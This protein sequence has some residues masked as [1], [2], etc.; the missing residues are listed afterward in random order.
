MAVAPRAL[1][2]VLLFG[3]V[4]VLV[5]ALVGSQ[6][7]A[8]LPLFA[9]MLPVLI[10]TGMVWYLLAIIIERNTIIE[11]I[12]LWVE[13]LIRQGR[14]SAHRRVNALAAF[15]AF[16]IIAALLGLMAR[17]R[18]AREAVELVV[19]S[20]A[21]VASAG[22]QLAG[23]VLGLGGAPPTPEQAAYTQ[24]IQY[25][26]AL[27]FG[28]IMVVSVTLIVLGVIGGLKKVRDDAL[29]TQEEVGS[30][31]LDT[32][33]ETSRRIEA[34]GDFHELILA[35]YKKMCDLLAVHGAPMRESQTPREFEDAATRVL[36]V[37]R[38]ALE[39]L[40]RLF[41]SARYSVHPVRD[42]DRKEAVDC[43]REIE[44]E[45]TRGIVTAPR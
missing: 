5:I 23:Q 6:G 21:S 38:T 16:A 30:L 32:V 44:G 28:V 41:E 27:V 43:L 24:L 31:T 2:P 11:V 9:A 45:L 34:G 7:A 33:R 36:P 42:S 19:G 15:V 4:S 18:S 20:V 35:C 14:P 17:S 10:M 25:T 40:T 22:Q 12:K 1:I 26:T 39:R 3:A 37:S 29:L 8:Q 13:Q